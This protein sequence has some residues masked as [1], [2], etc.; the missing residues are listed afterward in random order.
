MLCR[1]NLLHSVPEICQINGDENLPLHLRSGP[2]MIQMQA[3]KRLC[4]RDSLPRK[5]GAF[6]QLITQRRSAEGMAN[7]V[8]YVLHSCTQRRKHLFMPTS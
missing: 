6:I 3:E 2:R 5:K 7:Y 8:T 4:N 1:V